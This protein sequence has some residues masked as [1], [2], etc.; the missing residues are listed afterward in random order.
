MSGDVDAVAGF[1]LNWLVPHEFRDARFQLDRSLVHPPAPASVSCR[2]RGSGQVLGLEGWRTGR[3][4]RRSK[5]P[6]PTRRCLR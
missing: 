4:P 2:R 6:S 1:H 3:T 5:L